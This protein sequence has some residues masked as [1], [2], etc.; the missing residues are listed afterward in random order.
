MR[1][2]FDVP[3]YI[4][5]SLASPPQ[6]LPSLTCPL[7]PSY[8]CERAA[9]VLLG[10]SAL[11]HLSEFRGPLPYLERE[12]HFPV[13][14]CFVRVNV[15]YCFR[16]AAG[17]AL[18]VTTTQVA[19]DANPLDSIK[20]WVP[21]GAGDNAGLAAYALFLV[22]NDSVCCQVPVAGPCRGMRTRFPP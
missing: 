17:D 9:Q 7:R 5:I 1:W 11:D 16:F 10:E 18:G 21:E 6:D 20:E 3:L 22:N 19:L 15:L 14:A 12:L 13:H 2:T 4:S 8:I